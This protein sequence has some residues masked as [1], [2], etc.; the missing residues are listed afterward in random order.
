MPYAFGALYNHPVE[1]LCLDILGGGITILLSFMP[2]DPILA[3]VFVTFSTLKT[4][5]DHCGYNFPYDPFQILFPNNCLYHDVHHDLSGIKA[6]YSQPYFVFWDR[7]MSTYIDPHQFQAM[8]AKR[9]AKDSY[10]D[11]EQKK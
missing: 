4:V 3:A 6:N 11:S 10:S 9:A 8:K 2:N 1:A 7:V 5:D